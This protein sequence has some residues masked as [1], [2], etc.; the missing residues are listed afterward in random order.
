MIIK[1]NKYITNSGKPNRLKNQNMSTMN[2]II[3]KT[4]LF[5]VYL[6]LKHKRSQ[7]TFTKMGILGK[8]QS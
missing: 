8:R 7:G 2:K 3:N 6:V 1:K 5:Q 4:G